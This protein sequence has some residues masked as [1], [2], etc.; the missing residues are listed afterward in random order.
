MAR[1]RGISP[2]ARERISTALGLYTGTYAI[3]EEQRRRRQLR[4]Q[5]FPNQH[6]T[7]I[8]YVPNDE[9]DPNESSRV[10]AFRF[11]TAAEP[12]EKVLG[13]RYG[14]VFVR[15]IKHDTPWKYSN[16][17]LSV[18]EAFSASRSKGRFINSVLNNYPYGRATGDELAAYFQGM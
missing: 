11:V 13:D 3:E 10:R 5:E 6:L 9:H 18:Y 14:T 4:E 7:P 12:D 8:Q 16:V 15:F 17:P 1:V 2:K